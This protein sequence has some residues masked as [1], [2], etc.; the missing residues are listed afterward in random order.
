MSG[1][2]QETGVEV[3][4]ERLLLLPERAAL[5]EARETLLVADAHWGKAAAFRAGGLPVPEATTEDGLRRLD[6]IARRHRVRRLVYLGDFLHA[7]SGRAEVTFRALRRW[8]E[9][10]PEVEQLLVR[11]NH[12]RGAGDPPPELGVQV[13][14]APLLESPFALRH[15][16]TAHPSAY[17]LAGHIHPAVRLVGRGRQRARLPCFWLGDRV[18]VL[19]SFGDFTGSGEITPTPGDRVLVPVDGRVLEIPALP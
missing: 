8:S 17:T 18:M 2:F 9:A 13:V 11:G 19:P 16:P 12:D 1:I 4:G 5:W 3:A 15:F 14:D 10:H 6:E 7:R